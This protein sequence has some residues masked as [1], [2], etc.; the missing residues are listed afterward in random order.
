MTSYQPKVNCPCFS[1][2]LGTS[3]GGVKLEYENKRE[4]EK[5]SIQTLYLTAWY[6]VVLKGV[7]WRPVSLPGA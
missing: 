5:K 4:K 1:C 3:N 6:W 7:G 2:E